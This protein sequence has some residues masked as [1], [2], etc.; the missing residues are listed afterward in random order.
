[1]E[2][3]IPAA[4]PSSDEST[5]GAA[6]E[7]AATETASVTTAGG[8]AT[9][10]TEH[11]G[12]VIEVPAEARAPRATGTARSR[13]AART[14][15]A[16]AMPA[17]KTT[18][19]AKVTTAARATAPAKT[20]AKA[21][22]AAAAEPARAG[23]APSAEPAPASATPVDPVSASVA[24]PVEPIEPAPATAPTTT[25][26][27][28]P[29]PP[30]LWE[31]LRANPRYAPELLA[32]AAVQ[33]L[34]GQVD[35]HA[36]WLT[37]TY[38]HATAD[39]IARYAAR[40][41]ARQAGYVALAG[42]LARPG[43]PVAG[44]AAYIWVRARLVLLTAAAYGHDPRD[45]ERA[46][47]L[48][49]LLGVHPDLPAARAALDVAQMARQSAPAGA[50]RGWFGLAKALAA[51]LG[52]VAMRCGRSGSFSP[53]GVRPLAAAVADG[54]AAAALARRAVAMYRPGSRS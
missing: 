27:V 13:A 14:A 34:G 31:R 19:L 35:E 33:L 15:A 20:A 24:A 36:R 9:E 17:T 23:D 42:A 40:R 21:T 51:P 28:A 4:R 43:G 37:A 48:L 53:P 39:S 54:S 22:R 49:V 6:A 11:P 45:P 30:P 2:P 10:S 46:P 29:V 5:T 3:K 38:P 32:M 50:A 52:R 26:A 8:A 41:Y 18:P 25:T 7:T 16:K 1:M 47:E 12:D 44:L